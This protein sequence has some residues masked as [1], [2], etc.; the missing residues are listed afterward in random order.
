M[1]RRHNERTRVMAAFEARI[2]GRARS[3]L[4]A[5]GGRAATWGE[6]AAGSRFFAVGGFEG[7]G[8]TTGGVSPSRGAADVDGADVEEV[9][10]GGAGRSCEMADI[11]A[12]L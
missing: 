2:L 3:A 5:G 8:V 7:E 11:M 10:V 6:D 1:T 12:W 9:G 4:G